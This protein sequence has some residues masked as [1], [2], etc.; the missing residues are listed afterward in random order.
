MLTIKISIIIAFLF[1]ISPMV[2]A[3]GQIDV[4]SE[5]KKLASKFAH[6]VWSTS[7]G[8][9]ISLPTIKL[10]STGNT[11]QQIKLT[12]PTPISSSTFRSKVNLIVNNHLDIVNV[13]GG[14]TDENGTVMTF[15]VLNG[16]DQN[17]RAGCLVAYNE[18]T[19][20]AVFHTMSSN[21]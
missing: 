3:Q 11:I 6:Q 2:H 16:F 9:V 15:I 21:L 12:F 5:H 14:W 13:T 19:G 17:Q 8:S 7:N 20:V 4:T 10:L 1:F 18:K